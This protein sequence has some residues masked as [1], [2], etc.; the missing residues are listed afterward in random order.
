MSNNESTD[1][2]EQMIVITDN[3]NTATQDSTNM[4]YMEDEGLHF[5]LMS[6]LFITM[7][8]EAFEFLQI[9]KVL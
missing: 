5:Y 7:Y 2:S 3:H 6:H 4:L 1:A 9:A 8:F